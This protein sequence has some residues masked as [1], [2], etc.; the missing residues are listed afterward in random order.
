MWRKDIHSP[1]SPIILQN[2][3]GDDLKLGIQ[4]SWFVADTWEFVNKATNVV[5]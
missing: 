1:F 4:G 5:F 3:Q 2:N